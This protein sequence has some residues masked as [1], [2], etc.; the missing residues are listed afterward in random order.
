[1]K[2][3]TE[4]NRVTERMQRDKARRD[5]L[6]VELA[7]DGASLSK[8]AKAA[9]MTRAGVAAVLQRNGTDGG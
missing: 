9:R 8:V 3:E 1:M 7:T 2:P 5:E 4:L 6:I